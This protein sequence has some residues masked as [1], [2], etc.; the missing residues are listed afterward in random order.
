MA[1][2]F[3]VNSFFIAENVRGIIQEGLGDYTPFTC[4]TFRGCSI[5][6]SFRLTWP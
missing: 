3:R 5:P 4:P 2:Y 6:G 1:H